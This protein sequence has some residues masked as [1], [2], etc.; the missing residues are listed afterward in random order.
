[1]MLPLFVLY[2]MIIFILT[3]NNKNTKKHLIATRNFTGKYIFIESLIDIL[4]L[5]YPHNQNQIQTDR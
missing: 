1:M 5:A 2:V 3:T 4:T